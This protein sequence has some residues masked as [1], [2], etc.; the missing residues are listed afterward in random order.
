M[1][2]FEVRLRSSSVASICLPKRRGSMVLDAERSQWDDDERDVLRDNTAQAIHEQ[3]ETQDNLKPKYERRWIWELFQNA[4]D[5]AG[6]SSEVK[7]HLKLDDSF[8]FAHNGFPFKRKEVL[9]LIFHG[10]T[11]RESG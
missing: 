6:D 1:R 5:A 3:L 7:I 9:H 4:L 10:S 11:K 8:V 2:A